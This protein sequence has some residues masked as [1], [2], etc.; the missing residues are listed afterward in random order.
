MR[1]KNISTPAVVDGVNEVPACVHS[2]IC[3]A[4]TKNGSKL[5]IMLFEPIPTSKI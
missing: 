4:H 2:H 3:F 1:G 5:M